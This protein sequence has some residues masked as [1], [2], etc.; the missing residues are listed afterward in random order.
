[1]LP[2]YVWHLSHTYIGKKPFV[3]LLANITQKNFLSICLRIFFKHEAKKLMLDVI[4]YRRTWDLIIPVGKNW[5][6]N[7]FA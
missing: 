7:A 6:E 4:L 2:K 5:K 3:D 1:M